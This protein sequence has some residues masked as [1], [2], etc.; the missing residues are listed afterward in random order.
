MCPKSL[1]D[2]AKYPD[3]LPPL[4]T[5][6]K[7]FFDFPASTAARRSDRGMLL[8]SSK[9]TVAFLRKLR[10]FGRPAPPL[11]H[12]LCVGI[13]RRPPS[14]LTLRSTIIPSA[15]G[16]REV[17]ERPNIVRP[18]QK[19]RLERKLYGLKQKNPIEGWPFSF[20]LVYP[21]PSLG[22]VPNRDIEHCSD[23]DPDK[24]VPLVLIAPRRRAQA[25][26]HDGLGTAGAP[27]VKK[28]SRR[29]ID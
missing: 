28:C 4:L 22:G 16:E 19:G 7:R 5:N 9:R 12:G 2:K 18:G 26:R 8:N 13:S 10:I 14:L 6:V 17:L 29:S 15:S 24:K 1:D 3:C 21:C 25:I 11:R 23:L 27:G 20:V